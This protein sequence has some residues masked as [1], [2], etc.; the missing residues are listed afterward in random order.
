MAELL[1]TFLEIIT[2]KSKLGKIVWGCVF[3]LVIVIAILELFVAYG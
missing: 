1:A 2:P 3:V